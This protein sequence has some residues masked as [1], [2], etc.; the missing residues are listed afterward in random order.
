MLERDRETGAPRTWPLS[1]MLAMA[2]C[3]LGTVGFFGGAATDTGA[4][5]DTSAATSNSGAK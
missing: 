2:A 5:T 3:V 1:D 4:T